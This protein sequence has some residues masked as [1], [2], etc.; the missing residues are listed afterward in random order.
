M[1]ACVTEQ[2]PSARQRALRHVSA[3]FVSFESAATGA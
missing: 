3:L 2:A 1:S